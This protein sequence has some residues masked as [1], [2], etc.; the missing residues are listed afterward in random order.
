MI[1]LQRHEDYRREAGACACQRRVTH[2]LAIMSPQTIRHSE[3]GGEESDRHKEPFGSQ[4]PDTS[5]RFV[6]RGDAQYGIVTR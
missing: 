3:S 4:R 2:A 6:W 1:E 5:L